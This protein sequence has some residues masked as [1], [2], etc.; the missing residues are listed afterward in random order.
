MN[1]IQRLQAHGQSVWLDDDFDGDLVASGR[2]RRCIDGLCVS[3]L[4]SQL[5]GRAGGRYHAELVRRGSGGEA[6]EDVLF[7]LV[8]HEVRAAIP[9]QRRKQLRNQHDTAPARVPSRS[10]RIQ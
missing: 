5:A 6:A 10:R 4:T 8:A 7:S 9:F 3:G 2:L 1:P